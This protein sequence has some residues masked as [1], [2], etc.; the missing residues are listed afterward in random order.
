MT[1]RLYAGAALLVALVAAHAHAQESAQSDM[2]ALE[3][4][5]TVSIPTARGGDLN[6]FIEIAVGTVRQRYGLPQENTERASL[7][8]KLD[9]T[10]SPGWRLLISDRLD[11]YSDNQPGSS[12]TVNTLREAYAS[13]QASDSWILDFGRINV[14]NGVAIGYNPTD[15]FRTGALRSV[16]SIDP[17]SLKKNR[18]GSVMLRGQTLWDSGS[19]TAL[20]SPKLESQPNDA[21]F[22][23][24]LGA[25]NN[26]NRWLL[27]LGTRLAENF[28][29]Q[30]MLFGE[31][32][33]DPQLGVNLTGLLN[34]ATVAYA[35]WS[36]GR[37]RSLRSQALGTQEDEAFRSRLAAGLT[38]TTDNKMSYTLEYLYNGSAM[39]AGEWDALRKGSPLAYLQY[40]TVAQDIQ[41]LVTKEALF[42]YGT[43]HDAMIYQLDL[44]T[45]VRYNVADRS[46]MSWLEARYHWD[47]ADFAVQWQLNSG[48]ALSEF[49]AL[50]QRRILRVVGAYYFH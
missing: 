7:D 48:R 24:D 41:D 5:D 38:Y 40:R 49:G 16:S 25:T 18:L 39:S 2:G 36:G 28:N 26:A 32:H 20:F 15:F 4:A 17:A 35:E 6:A 27:S 9:K 37:N 42:F 21:S 19:L 50:P 11:I 10:L 44:T 46:K 8:L 12:S 3:L 23:V 47:H 29:P 34:D 45:M 31:D 13:W 33:G 1:M 43:W 14:R 30:W 22:N